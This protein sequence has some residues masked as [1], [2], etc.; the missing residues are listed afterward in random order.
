MYNWYV[1]VSRLGW[2]GTS[3]PSQLKST[4][5]TNCYTYTVYLLMMGCKNALDMYGLID[6][7]I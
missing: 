5:H 3:Q 2:G 7:I 4:T 6:E 1:S